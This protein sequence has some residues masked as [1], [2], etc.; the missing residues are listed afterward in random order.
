[1]AEK[2]SILRDYRMDTV[3]PLQES[4]KTVWEKLEDFDVYIE[5]RKRR[6]RFH[7][8]TA[9]SFLLYYYLKDQ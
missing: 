1:M 3:T 5:K 4:E 9:P 7:C 6:S 8:G 2:E